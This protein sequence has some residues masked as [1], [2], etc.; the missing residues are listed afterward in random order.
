MV[1]VRCEQCGDEV[2]TQPYRIERYDNIFCG[3]ECST[4]YQKSRLEIECCQCGEIFEVMKS[5]KDTAKF[6]SQK[7]HGE[8]LSENNTGEANPNYKG[9]SEPCVNCGKEVHRPPADLAHN[10]HTLC[11]DECQAEW[12]S[13]RNSGELNY[14]YEGA[15][16]A[17]ECEWCGD[18][19]EAYESHSDRRRFCSI[20]CRSEYQSENIVGED[21]P[22]WKGGAISY[23]PNWQSQRRSALE[24]DDFE[25]AVC[26][27]SNADHQEEYGMELSVHHIT[28]AR[29]FIDK[30][31][32]DYENANRINNLITLC[33]THHRE[34]EGLPVAPVRN[35]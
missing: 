1:T 25:C 32:I 20:E 33:R 12:Q 11:S 4:E 17:I 23:G 6:C 26:G 22:R 15:K 10:E 3:D 35:G 34:W 24:R 21:H 8:W 29:K 2:E 28:P 9:A 7:C 5:R 16:R 18:K 31:E 30:G 14:F 27:I 19:F 13:G